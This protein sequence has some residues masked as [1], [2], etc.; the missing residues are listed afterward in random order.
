[1]RP[2][3]RVA[4]VTDSTVSL[5]PEQVRGYPVHIVPLRLTLDGA[6]L[7]DGVD[8]TPTEFYRRLPLLK[9]H[10]TTS[11]PRPGDFLE[12]FRSAGAYAE[13]ILCITLASALSAT[14]DSARLAAEALRQER[15]DLPVRLLDSGTAG[16]ALA[17]TVLRCARAS[18]C[19]QGLEAVEAVARRTLERAHFLGVLET[20]Y[21]LWKGGRIPRIGLW[22]TSLLHLN[23]VLEIGGG[24]VRLVA[25]PRTKARA[26][27][28]L[29]DLTAERARGRPIHAH[30]LHADRPEE[31]E[32]LRRRLEARVACREVLIS[33]F[34]PSIGAHTGPGLLALGFYPEEEAP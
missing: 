11:A 32:D 28:R 15:P 9:S 19:G 10:P 25:R 27:E 16:G 30:I 3:P 8:L 17:L 24:T 26:L 7:R 23:P 5:S 2:S 14:Y 34:T 4:I 6:V 1:M 13:G 21:Y 22:A 12:A 29:V 20:L 33:V 31:A 18:L